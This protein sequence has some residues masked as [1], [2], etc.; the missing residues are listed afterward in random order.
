MCCRA[1][2]SPVVQV[3][4]GGEGYGYFE[5]IASERGIAWRCSDSLSMREFL[6]LANRDKVPDHSWLSKRRERGRVRRN[7]DAPI[8]L[9]SPIVPSISCQ[10]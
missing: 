4:G 7:R 5:V 10:A 8:G 9:F 3:F 1:A 2:S 6:R